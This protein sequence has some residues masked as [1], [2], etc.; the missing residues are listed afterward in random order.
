MLETCI[1]IKQRSNSKI[2]HVLSSFVW[3][4]AGTLGPFEFC[5]FF[6]FSLPSLSPKTLGPWDP[7]TVGPR[8]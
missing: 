6:F 5:V 2:M 8:S 3:F 4:V 7:G 1:K